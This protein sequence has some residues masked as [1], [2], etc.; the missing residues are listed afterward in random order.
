MKL[1]KKMDIVVIVILLLI[2]FIPYIML[3][4]YQSSYKGT[5]YAVIS[6]DGKQEKRVELTEQLDEEFVFKSS[7]GFNKVVVH[8]GKVGIVDADCK[9]KICINQGFI[10]KVGER[11]VCLPNRLVIEVVGEQIDNEGADVI[12]R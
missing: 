5:N 11:I 7:E 1:I 8:N 9:D 2:S 6:I 3:K 12:S 4:K 10:G